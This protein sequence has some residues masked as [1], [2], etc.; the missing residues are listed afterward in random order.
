[1][2]WRCYSKGQEGSWHADQLGMIGNQKVAGVFAEVEGYG[3]YGGTEGE[4][5][6][7]FRGDHH[8]LDYRRIRRQY[9]ARNHKNE[10]M[11]ENVNAVTSLEKKE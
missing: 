3:F 7:D 2:S 11:N 6:R 1:M 10:M 9:R 5:A 4:K 8:R